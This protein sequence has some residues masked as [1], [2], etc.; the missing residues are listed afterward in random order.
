MITTTWARSV[1]LL[2]LL[3]L[4]ALAPA[5][6]GERTNAPRRVGVPAERPDQA[7]VIVK[8]RAEGALMREAALA[9]G[10]AEP[11][12][13]QA[14]RL[15]QRHGLAMSDGHAVAAHTQVLHA[16]G[17]SSSALVERLR[18]D[19]DVE[20]AW[21]DERVRIVAA[22]NDPRYAAG[23]TTITPAAG[24]WYLRAPDSTIVS[25]VNAEAAWDVTPG[26]AAIVVAVI[27]TGVRGDHPDLAGKLLPGY[28]FVSQDSPGDFTTANDGDGRDADPSDPGDWV[29]AAEDASGPL[30]GCGASPSSWHGTQTA[31]LA[32][33]ATNNGVGMASVGRN[34]RI[35]PIRALGKCGGF[36]SD[37]VA[38][39]RWAAGL[40]NDPIQNQN[41]A[42]VI[43]LSLGSSGVCAGSLYE[44]AVAEVLAAGITIVA[45]A[46]N[47]NGLAVG[48]PANCAG[49][50]GVAGLRHTGTKVGYS[51]IGPEVSIAA[52]AGN[53]VNLSGQCLF[54]LLTTTNTGLTTPATNTYSD[55][56][57][58][59]LGTSFSSPL[60]AGA[61]GL[62]LAAN[63]KLSPVQIKSGM[64]T[65]A[66]VFP[67]SGAS[68]GTPACQPPS[69]TEQDECYCTT[70]TCGAGMLDVGAAVAQAANTRTTT[71]LAF[72]TPSAPDPGANVVLDGST[73]VSA[74][75]RT[76]SSY[77]WSP[78][79]LGG[80]A[81][82]QQ[83]TN[84]S[85]VTV[86]TSGG[87]T[88]TVRL[89][90]TDS[91]GMQASSDISV[92]VSAA[93]AP[94]SGGGG[95]T[96]L[97][98]LLGLLLATAALRRRA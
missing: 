82:L 83:P 20:G 39:M 4:S 1:S 47:E 41:P 49:V 60:V 78:V 46:G 55:G 61:A 72:A 66:R 53:C 93:T 45:A 21:V 24:Q 84:A 68:A 36:L 50:I 65:T 92:N 3:A 6:V 56:S 27:D 18:A 67:S 96:S 11:R 48:K 88:F 33:A 9:A 8:Y 14:A 58:S 43:N 57:N 75:G 19:P 69:S 71:A 97:P 26:S 85:T 17:L 2:S 30:A 74:P 91:T 77:Q 25:A 13:A 94:S 38:A 86:A 32:G 12:M 51:N 70:T 5:Q 23:Q 95:A 63:P 31:G 62:M 34:V 44:S 59:S 87:G 40:S 10:R 42:R 89:T 90:V 28:D 35:L 52:P 29:S 76:I 80:I 79:A 54:P 81:T 37:V 98:W 16:R 73:S 64:T 7:R 15:S 22:P